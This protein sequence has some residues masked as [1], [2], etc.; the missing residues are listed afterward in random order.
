MDKIR[1]VI[2]SGGKVVRGI[3]EETGAHIDIQEDGTIHIAAVEGPAGEAAR[4]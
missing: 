4:P 2:G 1:D 3:Q